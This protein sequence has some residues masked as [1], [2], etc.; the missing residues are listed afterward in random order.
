MKRRKLILQSDTATAIAASLAVMP[1]FSGD[2]N[3]F[4]LEEVKPSS[5]V[6]LKLAKGM[7]GSCGGN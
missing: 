5:H 2:E 1:V 4:H 7:C 3:P 6:E